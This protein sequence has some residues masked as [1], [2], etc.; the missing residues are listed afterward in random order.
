MQLKRDQLVV[1][2]VSTLKFETSP[3][4]LALENRFRN[5][6]VNIMS[7]SSGR[8]GRDRLL[9]HLYPPTHLRL[10]RA[11]TRYICGPTCRLWSLLLS[12]V[13]Y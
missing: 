10:P 6:S 11:S 13:L 2:D 1:G 4:E 7:P 3:L 9:A 12:Q 5:K 8:P